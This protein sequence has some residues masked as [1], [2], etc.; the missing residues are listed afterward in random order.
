MSHRVTLIPGD[1]AG[2]ELA[3]ATRRVIEATGVKI[4]LGRPGGGRRRHGP[5]SAATPC[6]TASSS[7]S[8]RTGRPSRARSPRR[9]APASARQRRPAQGARPVRLRPALQDYAG[10]RTC[11]SDTKVDLVIVRENTEDLYAGI[12]FEQRQARD[13]RA[14]RRDIKRLERQDQI[15]RTDSGISIKPISRHRHRADRQLRLRV[16]PRRTAAR[17]SPPS[18]RR[19]S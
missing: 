7:R 3:E 4:R 19:T 9:S 16:R 18:T 14:D 15:R 1:G 12:E 13:A 17:R 5:G 11:F 2:P 6:P 8:G 10:V